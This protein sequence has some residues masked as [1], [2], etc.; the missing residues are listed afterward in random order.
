MCHL[1]AYT[2]LVDDLC[3]SAILAVTAWILCPVA[4]W[5]QLR[6]WNV[7]LNGCWSSERIEVGG[8]VSPLSSELAHKPCLCWPSGSYQYYGAPFLGALEGK[9]ILLIPPMVCWKHCG[10]ASGDIY[11]Y[12]LWF[13]FVVNI[14]TNCWFQYWHMAC[15]TS[16]WSD[17][18]EPMIWLCLESLSA[19]TLSLPAMCLTLSWNPLVAY[20]VRV[21]QS[22]A[23][24]SHELVPPWQLMWM[25]TVV[26]SD[27]ISTTWPITSFSKACRAKN[28]PHR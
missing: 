24:K 7:Q 25:S 3:G 10:S 5:V 22:M 11:I 28:S 12:Y 21:L 15:N 18:S 27:T 13:K 20:H 4:A 1:A 8:E 14:S 16:L 19:V 23:H 17:H 2:H 6:S 9:H 26:L